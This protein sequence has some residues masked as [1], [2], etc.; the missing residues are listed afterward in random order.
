MGADTRG[1]QELHP[2]IVA[3]ARVFVD[4]ASR[5]ITVSECQHADAAGLIREADLVPLG[6]V[7]IG[8]ARGRQSSDE[9]TLFDGAGV[10]LQD[11]V[12]ANL[13]ARR[14]HTTSRGT[15]IEY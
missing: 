9:I 5:A 6:E 4:E 12:V 2:A 8:T 1:K 15:D 14:A 7:L 3:A 13:A 11:L 10:A